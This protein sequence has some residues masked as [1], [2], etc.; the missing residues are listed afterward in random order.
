MILLAPV[1]AAGAT[2]TL[3]I[4]IWIDGCLA[5]LPEISTLER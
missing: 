2:W 5:D 1:D 3:L 4:I